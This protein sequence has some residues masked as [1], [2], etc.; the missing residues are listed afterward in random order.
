MKPNIA[1]K[2][3]AI[4]NGTDDRGLKASPKRLVIFKGSK[5]KSQL[6]GDNGHYS[7]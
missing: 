7:K 2:S 3:K 6:Q 1:A 4:L 5:V